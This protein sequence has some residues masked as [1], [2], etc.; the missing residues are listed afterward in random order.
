VNVRVP[1]MDLT[2][3]PMDALC[4]ICFLRS[5][6]DVEA[7]RAGIDAILTTAEHV[8]RH[9]AGRR[10]VPDDTLTSLLYTAL[11]KLDA[12]LDFEAVRWKQ[13][14]TI[15]DDT[16]IERLCRL[17]NAAV[18]LRH[19]SDAFELCFRVCTR[20]MAKKSDVSIDAPRAKEYHPPATL[21]LLTLD[22]ETKATK[23]PAADDAAPRRAVA[24][25]TG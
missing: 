1:K 22:D 11:I 7:T 16:A 14:W 3:I 8:V 4:A 20:L 21:A 17:R 6:C 19:E 9:Y 12:A 15:S 10:V 24:Q 13:F 25:R 2:P 18:S 23:R 5:E